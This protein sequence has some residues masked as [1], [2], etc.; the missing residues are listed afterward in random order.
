MTAPITETAVTAPRFTTV[1]EYLSVGQRAGASDVHLGVDSPPVWRLNGTLQPIWPDA[2]PLKAE[3]TSA[4][5]EAFLT[6]AQKQQLI[7]RG[8][9][10]FA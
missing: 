1:D 2:P 4:L 9:A 5:A 8:D 7:E 10:D 6:D 3:E